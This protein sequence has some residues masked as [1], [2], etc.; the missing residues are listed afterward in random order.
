[1]IRIL[2]TVAIVTAVTRVYLEHRRRYAAAKAWF[3][4]GRY[5]HG[6]HHDD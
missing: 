2:A 3:E 4:Q 5:T 1:M 6:Y